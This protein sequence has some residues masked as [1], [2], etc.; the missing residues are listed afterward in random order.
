MRFSLFKRVCAAALLSSTVFCSSICII[1]PVNVQAATSKSSKWP[2]GPD[3]ESKSAVLMDVD[4]GTVLYSK[5]PNDKHFPASITKVMTALV[6]LEHS[7]LDETVTYSRLAV[8]Q[9]AGGTSS[10]ARDVGEKM[11]MEE[12]LYGMML[13]SA[14]ECAWAIAEHV[15]GTEKNFIKM[16][17]AKA[18]SLG[19]THTHFDNPNGLP[20]D[21]HWTS[22]LD[23]AKI[24]RAA[25]KNPVFAKITGTKHM[26]LPPTN[27]HKDPTPLNNHHCMLNFFHTS[28]YLYDYCVGGKTGYTVAARSTLV[29][30]A[31]KDGKTLVCVVMCAETPNHWLDTRKLMDWGFDNFKRVKVSDIENIT[32][33]VSKLGK[34]N[35]GA[36]SSLI[37]VD[38][39]S[40]IM[41][42]KSASKSDVKMSLS[43]S[44]SSSDNVIGL[45]NFKYGDKTVGN[46]NLLANSSDVK[47][48][49]FHNLSTKKGGSSVSTIQI[50]VFFIA[51]VCIVAVAI[52]LGLVF[53][54]RHIFWS[55]SKRRRDVTSEKKGHISYKKIRDN[56]HH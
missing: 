24:S 8:A 36:D 16:M 22:A 37:S 53:L 20:D 45:M 11:T 25:Y 27:K 10:I 35:Y 30:Y 19:C 34:S 55:I 17:N 44:T 14:N 50:N 1:S 12:S 26:V 13:E 51:I 56:D 6:A 32:Q 4:S 33:H 43:K 40:T 52:I 15:G 39:S 3:V 47:S 28:R 38:D 42:P 29:T 18:K 48:Y 46:C 23:M 9:S 21:K 2:K 31:K 5:K 41:I 49:P 7:S 54:L